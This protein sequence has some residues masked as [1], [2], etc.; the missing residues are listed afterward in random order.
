M[1]QGRGATPHRWLQQG[2]SA[3]QSAITASNSSRLQ[4]EASRRDTGFDSQG[5]EAR[6]LPSS[7]LL[8]GACASSSRSCAPP[9]QCGSPGQV[10]M[11]GHEEPGHRC[12]R[13]RLG[14]RCAGG[15]RIRRWRCP[16]GWHDVGRCG[17]SS[18]RRGRGCHRGRARPLHLRL[19]YSLLR[20]AGRRLWRGHQWLC[21]RRHWL[22][23]WG[24][25]RIQRL[26][27]ALQ[28]RRRDQ[29]DEMEVAGG[30]R[31]GE[32]PGG[33]PPPRIAR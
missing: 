28:D 30:T 32:G 9:P 3:G 23:W 5:A 29:Q 22:C 15:G 18:G 11:A 31:Q 14:P 12:C 21:G 17:P 13:A 1:P 24:D 8:R 33:P 20:R 6:L 2:D 25:R 4:P 19:V 10:D 26:R 27:E 7:W 16:P